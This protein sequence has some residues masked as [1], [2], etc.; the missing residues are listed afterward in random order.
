ML[1]L[2]LI[3][4][5]AHFVTIDC[6]EIIE[7]GINSV[8]NQVECLVPDIPVHSPEMM[9]FIK[10]VPAIHCDDTEAWVECGV[11]EHVS[12]LD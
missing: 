9:A 12:H 11:D 1:V 2:H 10:D 5:D 6:R 7:D 4:N 3:F 8:E